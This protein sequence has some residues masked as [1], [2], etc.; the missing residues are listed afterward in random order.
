MQFYPNTHTRCFL[1]SHLFIV[2]MHWEYFFGCP[3]YYM[4]SWFEVWEIFF[5]LVIFFFQ[6]R[7]DWLGSGSDWE[8]A[9]CHYFS[10][11][12]LRHDS[13]LYK[14]FPW[15]LKKNKKI[16]IENYNFILNA[17]K[18]CL[19]LFLIACLK[20]EGCSRIEEGN[21]D[22]RKNTREFLVE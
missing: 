20:E 18:K 15:F 16:F 9:G 14:C 11:F 12:V 6:K 13:S 4:I 3:F 10:P 1:R 5:L 7:N 19:Y 22:I 8:M 17:R 21:I 2:E